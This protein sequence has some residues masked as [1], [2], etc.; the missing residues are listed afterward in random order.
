M[1]TVNGLLSGHHGFII[2]AVPDKGGDRRL[3]SISNLSQESAV[4]VLTEFL[5]RG[6]G[7]GVWGTHSS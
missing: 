4:K 3:K 7:E 2:M 5:N 1:S 6:C